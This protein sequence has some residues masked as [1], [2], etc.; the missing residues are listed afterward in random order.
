MYLKSVNFVT[1][2]HVYNIL[3]MNFIADFNVYKNVLSYRIN[4]C[5]FVIT[6]YGISMTKLFLMI[7]SVIK[8]FF[9][10]L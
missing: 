9:H 5:N 6:K 10:F 2:L 4:V 1:T 8:H 7:N 3:K